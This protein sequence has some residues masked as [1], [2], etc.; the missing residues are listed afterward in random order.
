MAQS[1]LFH[2]GLYQGN[3]SSLNILLATYSY[4]PYDYG[5]TEVY[6]SGLAQY[7]QQKNNQVTVIAGMPPRAFDDH[8]VFFEDDELRAVVYIHD[9]IRII[10]VVLRNTGTTEIYSKYKPRWVNSWQSLLGRLQDAG[11]DI[12]HM[13]SNTAAIG[14]C[15]VKAFRQHSS[16][17]KTL[18]SYHIPLSCVK[19]N[20]LF[21]REKSA[22]RVTPGTNI[23]TA[24]SFS[25]KYHIPLG[26]TSVLAKAMPVAVPRSLPTAWRYKSLVKKFIDTFHHFDDDMDRWHVFSDEIYKI[27]LLNQVP[28]EKISLLRHGAAP[29]FTASG[30]DER[31]EAL[32]V[33]F[34]YVGRLEKAK[35]FATLLKAWNSLP[36]T[37]KRILRIAGKKEVTDPELASIIMDVANRPDIEWLGTLDQLT[38]AKEMAEVGCTIIPSECVEIGPL[39]F[40][41]AIASGTDVIASDI[42][43]CAELAGYYKGK[44]TLFSMGDSNA[45][46][47]AIDNFRFSGLQLKA[48]S[49]TD[50]YS[51]V[52]DT[53]YSLA[54]TAYGAQ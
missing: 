22:C 15:L 41:E 9:K 13:H 47:R 2:R 23:C 51:E 21:G 54:G 44:A 32:P 19:G 38:L 42:G 24:C 25:S 34:L 48:R 27:L 33:V 53:Y 17:A 12:L 45:L 29:V 1:P 43:G 14:L 46:A 30:L 6:V 50:N 3:F 52:L 26:L 39:V 36:V 18:A 4:Y 31:Q 35:G 16:R 28:A 8:P 49:S 37:S 7:L 20:L 40:H 10:G 5:G 11:W